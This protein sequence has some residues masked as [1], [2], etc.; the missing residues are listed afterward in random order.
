M[1]AFLVY[2]IYV[3]H[4]ILTKEF[5][6][7][8]A[9]P[10]GTVIAWLELILFPL[11]GYLFI[12]QTS[13]MLSDIFFLVFGRL[14]RIALFL[15][16]WWGAISYF[17]AGNWHFSFTPALPNQ[18]ARSQAFWM[19]TALVP[20]LTLVTMLATAIAIGVYIVKQNEK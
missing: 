15:G 20:I 13:D 7:S 18:D 10:Y 1:I 14:I 17:L 12:R 2:L 8:L 3:G 6:P 5:I 19:I 9:M 16:C 4:P 11:L